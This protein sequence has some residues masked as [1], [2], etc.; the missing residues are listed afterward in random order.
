MSV[1]DMRSSSQ[2]L[3]VE[4]DSDEHTAAAEAGTGKPSNANTFSAVLA[5]SI[6]ISATGEE[7]M[8]GASMCVGDG[9][10]R[11]RAMLLCASVLSICISA[12]SA[13]ALTG[14]GTVVE[15][16]TRKAGAGSGSAGSV[17]NSPRRLR[18]SAA[19]SAD[20]EGAVER[21]KGDARTAAG[22]EKAHTSKS[23]AK[24]T[25]RVL[26][27]KLVKRIKGIINVPFRGTRGSDKNL[28]GSPLFHMCAPVV[29]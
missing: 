3:P 16:E 15:I 18:V 19:E 21:E 13:G 24:V 11:A 14:C 7:S 1:L 20:A 5:M 2:V 27:W 23:S 10:G 26:Y 25:Q 9:A 6:S 12:V 29:G 22:S 8:T 4:S 17:A 28:E